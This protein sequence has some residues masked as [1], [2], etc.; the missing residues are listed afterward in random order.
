MIWKEWEYVYGKRV[1]KLVGRFRGVVVLSA[2]PFASS[3]CHNTPS[4]GVS[5]R[6][7]PCPKKAMPAAYLVT[8]NGG[9]RGFPTPTK[10]MEI[11]SERLLHGYPPVPAF[12]AEAAPA[13]ERLAASSWL[14]TTQRRAVHD[15]LPC[16][17]ARARALARLSSMVPRGPPRLS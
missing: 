15:T 14:D 6:S 13:A 11:Y 9:P 5:R 4:G 3:C 16:A 12:A 10:R 17:L 1:T 7:D 2:R 8:E